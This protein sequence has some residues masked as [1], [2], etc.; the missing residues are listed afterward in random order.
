MRTRQLLKSSLRK[1]PTPTTTR[2]RRRTAAE[3]LR[4]RRAKARACCK[5]VQRRRRSF[6]SSST[7]AAKL[8]TN[9]KV[10]DKLEALKNLIP[11]S[12]FN[13]RED[14]EDDQNVKAENL[15]RE[16]ADYI[17]LLRT[18]VVVL[19]RLIKFYGSANTT[20]ENQNDNHVNVLL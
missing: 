11:G 12:H 15:F 7:A 3:T 13:G 8:V 17:I 6:P 14:E 2:R 20:E 16:T 5:A 18:R 4:I 19:Q 1:T 9:G 10:S